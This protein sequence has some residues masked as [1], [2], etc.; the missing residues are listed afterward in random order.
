MK[1]TFINKRVWEAGALLFCILV[2]FW[3][4]YAFTGQ[5]PWAKND[6]NSYTLQ[7]CAWLQ[8]RLD[9]GQNYSHL[10]LAVYGGKYF[11]SFPPFPSYFMLP[12]AILFGEHTPDGWIALVCGLVGAVYALKLFWK[13]R[14][15]D[16]NGFFWVLFLTLGTNLLFVKVNG[17]VWFLAQNMS[18]T[19]TVM[20]F[21]YGKAGRTG[22]SLA[23]WA[24]S[25]GCRPL[26]IL[27]FPILAYINYEERKAELKSQGAIVS[28]LIPS[29]L[30][31]GII[32]V[33]Y[34]VL[35]YVR[36]GNIMEFG[37]NY[38]PEFVEA[39]KGQFHFSYIME[40]L[41]NLFRLPKFMEGG[42]LDFYNFNGFAFWLCIPIFISFFYYFIL[43]LAEG[44]K[45]YLEAAILLTIV[46]HVVC[47]L[48][49]K[50]M[51]GWHFGNR[52]LIDAL[53]CLFYGLLSAMPKRD[54][55]I[56]FQYGLCL[57]GM[58]LNAVGT[59]AVYNAWI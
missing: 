15:T 35:N 34:M 30:P 47:L 38:L 9:L 14:K 59:V 17:W 13:V 55:S 3:V 25:V 27:Y 6:Y 31:T 45:C 10:E 16:C 18:F 24:C 28:K 19:L 48:S 42:R 54:R 37:H 11:V 21:Y 1:R 12:F 57:L 8:G 44:K 26:Q 52:Y 53:P 56:R 50:T 51:G 36:F 2:V 46:I 32:A 43:K 7:A 22:L 40:N 29:L 33:S 58:L 41:E 4:I 5:W 20:A 49:H 23:L 39:P